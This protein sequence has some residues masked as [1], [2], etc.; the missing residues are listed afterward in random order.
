MKPIPLIRASI[1]LHVVAFA[2]REGVRGRRLWTEAGLPEPASGCAERLV[3]LHCVL[4]LFEIA[5]HASG[6]DDFGARFARRMGLKVLGPFGQ[7]MARAETL[8]QAMKVAVGQIDDHNTGARYWIV[9]EGAFVRFRRRLRVDSTD[10]RQADLLTVALMMQL[11]QR[12]AGDEWRPD[13]VELQSTGTSLDSV[14]RALD[15]P[16]S[17]AVEDRRAATSI[18]IPRAFLSRSGRHGEPVPGPGSNRWPGP[19]PPR[20][21]PGSL[22]LV[23]ESMLTSRRGLLSATAKASGVEA[24]TLQRHL[25]LSG[26]K[27]RD[28]LERVR[29]RKAAALLDDPANRMVDVAHALG[30]S[31]PAHFSR[32]FRRWTSMTP[33]AYRNLHHEDVSPMPDRPRHG[34][35]PGRNRPRGAEPGR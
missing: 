20:D 25:L 31:D 34:L 19:T 23:V 18:R 7:A 10:F 1:A 24:R 11:V 22:E 17:C 28:V 3:P 15:L 9:P 12:V 13:H 6:R 8:D 33:V 4:R 29:G 32:A 30:Y 5:G 16:P 14:R 2:K 27:F 26:L 21:F 35:R